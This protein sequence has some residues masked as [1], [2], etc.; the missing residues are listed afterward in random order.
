[1]TISR[2]PEADLEF[3]LSL[4]KLAD[5]AKGRVK[6]EEFTANDRN[7][8]LDLFVNNERVLLAVHE[9]IFSE[10]TSVKHLQSL[11]NTSEKITMLTD[12][13]YHDLID[14][15][16]SQG[17]LEEDIVE[18]TRLERAPNTIKLTKKSTGNV[19]VRNKTLGLI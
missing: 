19:S 9:I 3:E 11:R 5:L 1:M 6:F 17:S 18:H 2:S 12:R 14:I 13:R 10:Q 4:A 7:N 8:L 15:E 16:N